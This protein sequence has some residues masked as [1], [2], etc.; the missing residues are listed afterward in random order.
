MSPKHTPESLSSSI[1]QSFGELADSLKNSTPLQAKFTCRKVV[2][3]LVPVPYS[4]E[5]IRA[6]RALLSVSQPLFAQ[7]IGVKACTVKSWEQGRLQPSNLVCR[8]MDAMVDNPE[9]FRG[10]LHSMAKVKTEP[11]AS[12]SIG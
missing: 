10:K 9:Y 12:Q 6:I 7:F 3:D 4:P 5:R 11:P 8:L 2:L 1:V